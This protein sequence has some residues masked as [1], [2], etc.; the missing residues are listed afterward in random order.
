M[1][2]RELANRVSSLEKRVTNLEQNQKPVIYH[3]FGCRYFTILDGEP[4]CD[5]KCDMTYC[6]RSCF[7]A[8]NQVTLEEVARGK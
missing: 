2:N 7:Y 8:T 3:N 6:T 1:G 5:K 4:K